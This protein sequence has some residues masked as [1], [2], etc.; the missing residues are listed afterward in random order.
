MGINLAF[1][2]L[3]AWSIFAA[4]LREVYGWT[5]TQASLPYTMAV[6]MFAVMMITGGRFQDKYGPRLAVTLAGILVG[7]GMILASLFPTVLGLALSFGVLAGSGIGLGYSATTP[8]AI[9]WFPAS[10]KGLISGIV[11]GGFGAATLY[12][13]PLTNHLI[14]TYGIFSSFRILGIAFF[15]VVLALAQ[16][17]RNP[18]AQPA[19]A[20]SSDKAPVRTSRDYHWKEMI[21]TKQFYQL[22]VMFVAGSLA[23]LMIIGHLSTIAKVQTG[24]NI[25]FL[26]VAFM[27]I[28]NALGRPIAGLISD[29]L[30]RAKTMM[31]L[32]I[33]QGGVLLFFSTFHSFATILFGAAVVTFAYGAMLSVYPSAAGDFYGTKNLG[34]NYGVLFTAWGVGGQIGPMLAGKI[35]DMTGGYIAAYYSA[36]ALC[37]VA[38]FIGFILKPVRD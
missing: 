15:V 28:T 27:A 3:Y 34:M 22:W 13:A 11:V 26:L 32:Y 12:I 33:A 4:N 20:Q 30:G 2:V 29:K 6:A 16:T 23:G 17:L 35:L 7:V 1:G 36:A 24:Q 18:D 21:R 8:V 5:S 19:P 31:I 10:R 38:A 37:F 25:G 9:K 14:K